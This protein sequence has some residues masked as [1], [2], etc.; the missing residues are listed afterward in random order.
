MANDVRLEI[1]RQVIG[2]ILRSDQ[3]LADL[4]RRAEAVATA[5][6]SGDLTYEVRSDVGRNRARA[7][8]IAAGARTN[9]HELAHHDLARTIDH[10]R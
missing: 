4:V 9:A 6:S 7:A 2:H 8:V 10:A 5:T 1:N 3:V